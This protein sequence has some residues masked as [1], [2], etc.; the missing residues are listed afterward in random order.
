MT[1][2]KPTCAY[3][4]GIQQALLQKAIYPLFP[5]AATAQNARLRFAHLYQPTSLVGGDFFHVVRISDHEAGVFVCDVMGHGVRSA[6]ITAMLAPLIAA[7]SI[8]LADPGLLM[9]HVNRELTTILKQTGTVLF[10]TALYCVIHCAQM[11]MRHAPVPVINRL[12]T[13]GATQAKFI[14]PVTRTRL[15]GRR[16]GSSKARALARRPRN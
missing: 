9:T 15:P 6:F 5:P 2:W 4:D 3:G 14:L 10:V 12:Y 8:N 11:T 13:C 16:S 7:E 1:K